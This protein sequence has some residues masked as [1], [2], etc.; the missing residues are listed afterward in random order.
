[1][2]ALPQ[3]SSPPSC[4]E[5]E[6]I[7]KIRLYTQYGKDERGLKFAYCIAREP[8]GDDDAEDLG[9]TQNVFVTEAGSLDD[10]CL[11]ARRLGLRMIERFT[12]DLRQTVTVEIVNAM[13]EEG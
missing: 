3:P 12:L 1:M 8:I 10:A 4:R 5:A 13:D 11:R 9:T 2:A 7:T 6:P